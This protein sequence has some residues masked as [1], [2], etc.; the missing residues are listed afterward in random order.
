MGTQVR[1]D[2]NVIA[3][4]E[5][6]RSGGLGKILKVKQSRNLYRPY[7]HGFGERKVALVR[8]NT[9]FGTNAN[10]FL[11]FIGTRGVTDCGPAQGRNTTVRQEAFAITG[12]GSGE[13]D[14]IVRAVKLPDI[15]AVHHMKN[16][17]DCVR[18]RKEPIAP[19]DAGLSH[20]V[21]VIMADEALVRGRRMVYDVVRR[22]IREG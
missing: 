10:T 14:K 2:A 17:L 20:A 5:F 11:R 19:I 1:S 18:S 4:R 3:A 16:W 21:A 13:P 9:V 15:A 8:Y 22:E 6:I 12:E 7:W